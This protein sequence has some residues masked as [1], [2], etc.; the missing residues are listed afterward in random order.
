[1]K[2][3]LP[4]KIFSCLILL[5]LGGMMV[6]TIIAQQKSSP[7]P[8]P[9]PP[10]SK[11]TD[12]TASDDAGLFWSGRQKYI[13]VVAASKTSGTNNDLP[14]T[15]VDGQLVSQSFTERGYEKLELLNDKRA[16]R[17]NFIKQLQRIRAFPPTAVVVVYYSGHAVKDPQERDLWLQLYGQTEFGDHYGLSMSEIIGAARGS[18]FKGD[19][20]IILDS[21]YSGQGTVTSQLSLRE[22]D[23]TVIFA[24]SATYQQSYSVTQPSGVEISAFTHY[25]LRALGPDWVEADGDSDGIILYSDLQTYI[26]NKLLEMLRDKAIL[27]LMQPQL[28]GQSPKIWAAYDARQARNFESQQRKNLRLQRTFQMQN[29][30]KLMEMIDGQLPNNASA[31]MKALQAIKND[32]LVAAWRLLELAEGEKKVAVAEIYWAR[33]NIKLEQGQIADALDWLEKAVEASPQQNVD[34]IQQTAYINFGLSNWV[35]A[36]QLL[37]QALGLIGEGRG[38]EP[39]AIE[40]LFI[41]A[42]VNGFQGDEVEAGLYLTRLKAFDAKVLEEQEE[43]LSDFIPFLEALPDLIKGKT[44]SAKRKLNSMKQTLASAKGQTQVALR[45]LIQTI[46]IDVSSAELISGKALG[47]WDEALQHKN[48]NNLILFLNQLQMVTYRSDAA[49]FLRSSEVGDL[50]KRTVDFARQHKSE[51]RKLTLEIPGGSREV[52]IPGSEKQSASESATILSILGTVYDARR[53]VA[54][55]EKLFKEAIVIEEEEKEEKF[56]AINSRIKLG[57]LY[58]RAGRLNDAENLYK[59]SL[60]KIRG[61]LGE[62]N[63]YALLIHKKLGGLFEHQERW[64]EAEQNYQA[65]AGVFQSGNNL[66]DMITLDG[67]ESLATFYYGRGRYA[68]A[69]PLLEQAVSWLERKQ[70]EAPWMVEDSLGDNLFTLARSYYQAGRYVEAE[71]IFRR[72]AEIYSAKEDPD[73]VDDLSCLVWQWHAARA[74]K[75]A[76]EASG[77]YQKILKMAESELTQPQPDTRV[78]PE[79]LTFASWFTNAE[80]YAEAERLIRVAMAI[81]EKIYSPQHPEIAQVW[82]ASADLSFTRRQYGDAL[83]SLKKARDIY[84]KQ[85]PRDLG[86]LYSVRFVMGLASYNRREIEQARLHLQEAVDLLQQLPELTSVN[87]Y[88]RFYLGRVQRMLGQYDLAKTN[89][90]SMLESDERSQKPNEL[91]ILGDLLELASVSRAGGDYVDARLWLARAEALLKKIARKENIASGWAGLAYEKGKLALADGKAKQAEQFFREAVE[92]GEKDP[93]IDPVRLIEFIDDYVV[94]LRQRG[95]NKEATQIE[96][97]AKQ[98]RNAF[99]N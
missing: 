76:E 91:N 43:G 4:H 94:V 51:K 80:A 37:K 64:A 89:I 53:E 3:N 45:T 98:V 68:E 56:P 5:V 70:K 38:D 66:Y 60:T 28:F 92:N 20:V 50:L 88:A 90:K 48:I 42:L 36:E 32:Q 61:T 49:E 18:T 8:A 9:R 52:E 11:P 10:A 25:L 62:P 57:D 2:A 34:L 82:Q 81:Q 24:S 69:I 14:F 59:S 79:L 73:L 40:S 75:K 93:Q 46:D 39:K 96:Q 17:D 67:Q 87:S 16:T 99:T 95:K 7:A 41:L 31:Y 83:V 6:G 84:E 86:K 26:E 54:E 58:E 74:L 23:K 85:S 12:S 15:K 22:T 13:L 77:F 44:E 63:L 1:M 55:A 71:S 97:R 30:E 72:A 78:G 19:L 65:L 29:P 33:A 21:C 35:R 47:G 27:G